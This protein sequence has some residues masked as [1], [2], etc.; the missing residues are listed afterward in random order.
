MANTDKYKHPDVDSMVGDLMSKIAEIN[1]LMSAL[2]D[3]GVSV[4]IET[5]INQ[6][7]MQYVRQTIDYWHK[8][9]TERR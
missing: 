5:K 4:N 8:N 2:S 6:L 3:A 1:D 7:Q 9:T